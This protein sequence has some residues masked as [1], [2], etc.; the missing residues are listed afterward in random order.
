MVLT[1]AVA[2]DPAFG[3]LLETALHAPSMAPPR[4]RPSGKETAWVWILGLPQIFVSYVITSVVLQLDYSTGWAVFFTVVFYG[5]VVMTA[6]GVWYG[7]RL[8][9]RRARTGA[10]TTATVLNALILM[11]YF[12][13]FFI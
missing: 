10:L 7:I 4:L 2:A 1:D 8:M 3:R 5:S 12:R 11:F 13:P 6:A 9:R